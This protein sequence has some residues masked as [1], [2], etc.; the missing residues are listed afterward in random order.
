M[1]VFQGGWIYIQN[2]TRRTKGYTNLRS[3]CKYSGWI[4]TIK[5]CAML[6]EKDKNVIAKRGTQGD[7]VFTNQ[8]RNNAS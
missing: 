4:S 7:S 8:F 3:A 2:P 1:V 5:Q 6:S